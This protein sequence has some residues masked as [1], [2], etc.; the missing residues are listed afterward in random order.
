MIYDGALN[1][2]LF[3]NFLR[4]LIKDARRKVFLIVDNVRVHWAV[5]VTAWVQANR[6]RI[7][8]FYLPPYA[9]EHI[10]TSSCTTTSSKPWR[11]D[12]FPETRPR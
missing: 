9:P 5:S 7:A 10:L 2:V 8:L 6:E 1:A 4:R 12:A 3:L 11:A